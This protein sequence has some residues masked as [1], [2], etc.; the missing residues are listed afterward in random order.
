ML[1]KRKDHYLRRILYVL[2]VTMLTTVLLSACGTSGDNETENANNGNTK[3]EQAA[4]NQEKQETKKD[5][6]TEASADARE[7]ELDDFYFEPE[8]ITIPKGKAV[9]LTLHNEGTKEHD[10]IVE[11]LGIHADVEPGKTKKV[12]V[13]AKESGTYQ[14]ICEYHKDKGMTGKL[15]VE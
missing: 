7:I 2:T 1:S 10:F 14:L 4:E 5:N 3:N 13:T 8:K 6:D 12:E 11:E 9:T 15:I